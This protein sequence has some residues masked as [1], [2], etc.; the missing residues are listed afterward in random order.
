MFQE[1]SRLL[2]SHLPGLLDGSIS[3]LI[4][5]SVQEQEEALATAADK[6]SPLDARVD[7]SV[8][9]ARQVSESCLLSSREMISLVDIS[10]MIA[11][12]QSVSSLLNIDRIQSLNSQSNSTMFTL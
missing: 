8:L 11:F 5:S 7:L 12:S 2:I 10:L 3:P 1:G 9:T 6:L 4:P